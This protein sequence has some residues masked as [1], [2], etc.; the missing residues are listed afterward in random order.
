[1]KSTHTKNDLKRFA[2]KAQQHS[3]RSTS[4]IINEGR[5]KVTQENKHLVDT[6]RVDWENLQYMRNKAFRNKQYYMGRHW[7]ERMKD[8]NGKWVTEKEHIELTGRIAFKQN[9]I[10]QLIRNI[11]GTYRGNPTQS[12]LYAYDNSKAQY[13]ETLGVCLE[14]ALNSVQASELDVA[15]LEFFVIGGLGVQKVMY[16]YNPERDRSDLMVDMIN[17]NRIFF[18]TDVRDPR[19]TDI[20]RIGEIKDTTLDRIIASFAKTKEDEDAL[21]QI[22]RGVRDDGVNKMGM[23]TF[24]GD[25][26]NNLSFNFSDNFDIC[27]VIEVWEQKYKWSLWVHDNLDASVV[28]MDMKY[29]KSLQQINAGRVAD[30]LAAGMAEEE[31]PLI[32]IEER[33]EPVFYYKFLSPEGYCLGEGE[34]P[35][36]HQQHPYV[37]GIQ[38]FY[39]GEISTVTE[40]LIDHNR[41]INRMVILQDAVLG[42]AAKGLLMVPEDAIPADMNLDDFASEWSKTNGVVKFRAKPGVALPQIVQQNVSNVGAYEMLNTQLKLITDVAGVSNALQGQEAKAG[43]PSSLY[44]QMAQNSMSNLRDMFDRF[45]NFKKQ[46]DKKAIKVI[47]QYYP[48]GRIVNI[49]GRIRNNAENTVYEKAMADI[50]VDINL[51][52]GVDTPTYKGMADDFL[53]DML[54]NKLINLK[55]FLE[56]SNL[57]FADRLLDQLQKMEQQQPNAV[58]PDGQPLPGGG[59]VMTPELM[60]EMQ[61]VQKQASANSNPRTMALIDQMAG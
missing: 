4:D 16:D 33:Y 14:S 25:E 20:Y 6:C 28:I 31:I 56:N 3:K 47:Q 41:I 40:D 50:D 30:G 53:L 37:L 51:Q 61:E 26:S 39:D 29:K 42:N 52:Q 49:G 19:L 17:I 7:Y 15:T 38:S 21:R 2:I 60:A 22:Y 54:K 44:A 46:R 58:G 34:N 23:R 35:Y 10:K 12:I 57:P 5:F 24:S 32:E 27:R 1:M 8:E 45:S 9:I 11:L 13:A 55:M 36:D 43:T 48:D 18:N 59:Q